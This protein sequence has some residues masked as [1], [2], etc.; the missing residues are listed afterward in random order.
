MKKNMKSKHAMRKIIMVSLLLLTLT[1]EQG[2]AQNKFYE[3]SFLGGVTAAG[4]SPAYN[5]G[6]TGSFTL[7]IAAGSTIRQ[8]YLIAGRHGTAANITVTLN[9]ISYTFSSSNQV[10]PTFQSPAYGG[11]SGVHA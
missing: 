5:A 1:F 7:G 10:S 3:D 8:A 11:N 9:G 4:Y 6:G 2:F